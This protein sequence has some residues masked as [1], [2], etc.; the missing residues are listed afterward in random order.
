MIERAKKVAL[1]TANCVAFS[2]NPVWGVQ[3]Y[4][5]KCFDKDTGELETADAWTTYVHTEV[6]GRGMLDHLCAHRGAPCLDHL[7]AHRGAPAP[8]LHV[9]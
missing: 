8:H 7:C 4:N 6:R 9:H 2:V 3:F 5:S 1:D